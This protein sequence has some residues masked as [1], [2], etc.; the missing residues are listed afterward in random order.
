MWNVSP[1]VGKKTATS[2]HPRKYCLGLGFG[3]RDEHR[4]QSPQEQPSSEP[5]TQRGSIELRPQPTP[6]SGSQKNAN[7]LHFGVSRHSRLIRSL[8][9]LGSE[10]GCRDCPLL[11]LGAAPCFPTVPIPHVRF[12]P[13]DE[14][15][16]GVGTFVVM[17][18][19]RSATDCRMRSTSPASEWSTA[20][21]S[22][23]QAAIVHHPEP[24]IVFES[25]LC[26][27]DYPASKV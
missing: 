16:K 21:S 11:Q 18:M 9:H 10:S 26:T 13:Q 7:R 25:L 1:Y 5:H 17:P 22:L 3:G 15:R 24:V 2:T 12:S 8:R 23:P 19:G 6:M 14:C 27:R 4:P 20:M